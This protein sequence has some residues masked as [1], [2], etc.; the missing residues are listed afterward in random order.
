MN[1]SCS[2]C[3]GVER[4]FVIGLLLFWIVLFLYAHAHAFVHPCANEKKKGGGCVRK[5]E[6]VC[7]RERASVGVCVCVRVC[8]RVCGR[9]SKFVH[10]CVC[11]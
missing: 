5:K 8:V 3:K 4:L 9:K 1:E 11:A 2:R 6:T 7:V 10:A